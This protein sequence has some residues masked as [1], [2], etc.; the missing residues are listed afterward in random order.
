MCAASRSRGAALLVAMLVAAL[1]AVI[2][3]KV[4]SHYLLSF[5]RSSN[6][7][8]GDQGYLYLLSAEALA[9]NV[10]IADEDREA[11]HL[12]EAWAQKVEPYVI[13]GGLLTGQIYDLQAR[14][15]VNN[16]NN[17]SRESRS[18]QVAQ[19]YTP[20]Q[21][22]FMRLLR[23]F[24]EIEVTEQQAQEITNAAIDWL[25][26]DAEPTGFSGAEDDYYADLDIP[27]RAAN[28]QMLSA[29]ELRLVQGM[30]PELYQAL[31][32]HI[33]ALPTLTLI[34]TNTA[35]VN[36]LRSVERAESGSEYEPQSLEAIQPLLERREE[37]MQ[38]NTDGIDPGVGGAD[39]Q[40]NS[41]SGTE[42]GGGGSNKKNRPK[43]S[44][45]SNYFLFDGLVKLGDLTLPIKSILH[46]EGGDGQA[47]ATKNQVSV[48]R[49]SLGS[50]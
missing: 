12:G 19:N 7:L 8:L 38:L 28:R 6:M 48:I 40:Q 23:T 20:E 9:K 10:L 27:Y 2:A 21:M 29:S 24:D 45:N 42:G 1:V 31:A 11:D 14:F 44:T 33:V 5:R 49:R 17:P 43:I 13:D 18:R 47:G 35:T 36:V 3:T 34:N 30:T 4:G 50:L 39:N 16:L 32:P 26:A 22:I 37:Q 25:D 15:N 41:R 46:R